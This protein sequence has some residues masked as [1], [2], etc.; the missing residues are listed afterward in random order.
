MSEYHILRAGIVAEEFVEN[1][2]SGVVEYFM[3]EGVEGEIFQVD[4]SIFM[5]NC[6]A[7]RFRDD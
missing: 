3:G 2:V 5:T 7:M 6:S 4:S 1:P